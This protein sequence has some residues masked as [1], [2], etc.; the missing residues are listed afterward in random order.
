[1]GSCQLS[2]TPLTT[3]E[4]V[5]KPNILILVQL[6]DHLCA[7]ERR[8]LLHEWVRRIQRIGKHHFDLNGT[9]LASELFKQMKR[10]FLFSGIGGIPDWFGRT[11][12]RGHPLLFSRLVCFLPGRQGGIG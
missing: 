1:V 2:P 4:L 5:A 10:H 8:G 9:M 3:T 7:E 6:T 12:F 11:V